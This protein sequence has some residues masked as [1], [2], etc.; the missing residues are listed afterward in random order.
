[1][2]TNVKSDKSSGSKSETE[3]MK[4]VKSAETRNQLAMTAF[5]VFL[6]GVVLGMELFLN[7]AKTILH[8]LNK[9]PNRTWLRSDW[10]SLR[11]SHTAGR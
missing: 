11:I 3:R 5:C 6:K 2:V 9:T 1:M 8:I 10:Y 4:N 7:P